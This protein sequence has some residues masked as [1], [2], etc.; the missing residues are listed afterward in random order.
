[1]TSNFPRRVG[2]FVVL[3]IALAVPAFAQSNKADI[4]GTVT[5]SNGGG[6]SGAEVTATKIDTAAS[7]SATTDTAG[8]FQLPLLDIGIYKV[9]ATKQGFQTVTQEN[10]TLQTQDRLRIDLTLTPGTVT[11]EVTIT[12]AAPLVET[13]S[14]DRG[15]VVTGRKVTELPFSG[16]SFTQL[17]TLMPGV[18]AAG[19]TGF[20]G[21]GPDARQ[22]NNGDPRAGDGGPGSSN[23]QGST[24]NSRFARSGSGALTVNGQRSTNNNFSLDGVD[25]NESQFGTIGIFPNPDA[26]AEFKVSTSIPPAEVGRA[27]GAVINTTTKSGTNDFHGSLYYYGQ[28]SALNAYHPLLKRD[29]A[30]AISRGDINIPVKAVQ[31]IHEFGGTIG[32]PIK[33]DKLF[34]FFDYLGQRNHL[35][36]PFAS[37]VPTAKSRTGDFSEF[38]ACGQIVRDPVTNQPFAGNIIPTSRQDPIARKILGLYPLPTANVACPNQGTNNYFGL[39]NVQ[40]RINDYGVKIDYRLSTKNSLTGR[41]NRQGLA[42]LRDNFFP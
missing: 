27:A 1:M 21:T 17:A 13:E 22:F 8:N 36:F 15:T 37:T 16:R 28:N 29:R 3:L 32:G 18:A 33:H 39:R 6:V 35:P 26:I 10:V 38:L 31:Q 34:F 7:R 20:G 12:A 2:A 30:L 42:N 24:E 11:G 14:S 25:N 23:S 41:Y 9:T 5:D 4:V 40:E 19:N